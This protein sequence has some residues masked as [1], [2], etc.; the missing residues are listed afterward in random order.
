MVS[1]AMP[2]VVMIVIDSDGG[3]SN[4]S[5]SHSDHVLSQTLLGLEPRASVDC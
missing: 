1:T 2:I 5:V 3:G 4:D